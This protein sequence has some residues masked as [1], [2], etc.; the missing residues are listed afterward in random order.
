MLPGHYVGTPGHIL[1]LV[2]PWSL[3][4]S[5]RPPGD[6]VSVALEASPHCEQDSRN[7]V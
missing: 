1:P 2:P 3:Q 7:R 5:P 4:R 6:S